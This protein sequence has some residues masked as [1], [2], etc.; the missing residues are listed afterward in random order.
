MLI[1]H[2]DDLAFGFEDGNLTAQRVLTLVRE[3]FKVTE[4]DLTFVLGMSVNT[5][6]DGSIFVEQEAYIDKVLKRFGWSE[7]ITQVFPFNARLRNKSV[8]N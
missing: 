1:I 6:S 7:R 2:A 3:E 5:L 8:K 4:E